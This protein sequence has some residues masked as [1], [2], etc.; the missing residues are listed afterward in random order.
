MFCQVL[1]LEHVSIILQEL[2]GGVIGGHF[3]FDIIMRKILDVGYW[4]L[5]MNGDVYGYYQT[6]DQCQRLNNLLTQNLAKLVTTLLAKPFQKWGLDFIGPIK[7][8]SKLSSNRNI[9]VAI[10]YVTKWVEA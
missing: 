5:M 7:P 1:Q 8:T 10:N 9:L 2:H 6:C 4:R 3:S